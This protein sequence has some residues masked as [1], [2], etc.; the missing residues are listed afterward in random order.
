VPRRFAA[1]GSAPARKIASVE[2]HLLIIQKRI[3]ALK[4]ERVV[5]DSIS[6]FLHKVTDPQLSREKVF[7]LCITVWR[8]NSYTPSVWAATMVGH[9]SAA[10]ANNQMRK[11]FPPRVAYGAADDR[12][13]ARVSF[14]NQGGLRSVGSRSQTRAFLAAAMNAATDLVPASS[15]VP[16]SRSTAAF[17]SSGAAAAE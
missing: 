6:V 16:A 2:A 11:T 9:R 13:S 17:C 5:V 3:E 4:A 7:Q 1:F 12:P 15:I 14:Q 8:N 10:A